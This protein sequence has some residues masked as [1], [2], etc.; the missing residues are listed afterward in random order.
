[1]FPDTSV[2]GLLRLREQAR[3]VRSPWS[4]S[5]CGDCE[6]IFFFLLMASWLRL[7]HLIK[8]ESSLGLCLFMIVQTPARDALP[9]GW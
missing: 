9:R 7:L 3:V 4:L 1:M 6:Q 5:M 2:A 8:P